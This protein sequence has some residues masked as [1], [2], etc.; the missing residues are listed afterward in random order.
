MM[1]FFAAGSQV[2]CSPVPAQSG[3][4]HHGCAYTCAGHRGD[5]G[6]L[7]PGRRDSPAAAG[8]SELRSGWSPYIPWSFRRALQPPISRPQTHWAHPTRTFW[9]GGNGTARSIPWLRVMSRPRLFSKPNGEGSR[10]LSAARVSANLFSTLG[11]APALGRT[12]NAEEELAGHR[13][14]ILSHELWVSDF[15]SSP[16][17]L[18]QM[19]KISDECLTPSSASCRPG[20]TS[21]SV[22]LLIF[23]TPSPGTQRGHSL[24]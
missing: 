1:L 12:F 19:V 8:V 15:A 9:N 4:H 11:V 14:V 18:G 3:L 16:N 21:R 23:G 20:F 17:A 13:A 2:R 22:I 24:E 6:D 5:D 7:Q 10:V